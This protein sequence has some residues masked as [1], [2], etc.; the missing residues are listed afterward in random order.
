MESETLFLIARVG[1][2]ALTLAYFGLLMREMKNGIGLTSWTVNRKRRTIAW[3]TGLLCAWVIFVAIWSGSGMMMRFS[4]FPFNFMP[5]LLPPLVAVII[6]TVSPGMTTVLGQISPARI[7]R[8]QS[9]RFFVELLLWA[10]FAA[11]MLPEQMTF[12]GMNF[13][14][15]AG[16]TAP[17]VALLVARQRTS[18]AFVI[19]RNIICLGLLI[20]EH[21]LS[22][23]SH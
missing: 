15:L 1:F 17:V 19:A 7:I 14:I 12:E 23:P 9:F 13:D 20:N 5:I 6:L 21:H 10:L 22:W 11:H 4:I 3:A 18:R 2:P 16:I 8:L